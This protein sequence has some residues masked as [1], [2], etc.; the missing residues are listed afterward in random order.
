MGV[1]KYISTQELLLSANAPRLTAPKNLIFSISMG[2][3]SVWRSLGAYRGHMRHAVVVAWGPGHEMCHMR[4][5]LAC[6][7]VPVGG[8][9]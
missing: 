9:T 7:M 5:L 8:Q 4:A 6:H 1:A 2:N 3:L